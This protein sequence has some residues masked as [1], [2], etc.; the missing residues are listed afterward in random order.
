MICQKN[1]L[2]LS[3]WFKRESDAKRRKEERE[4]EEKKKILSL[5]WTMSRNPTYFA[6]YEYELK[7]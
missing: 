5:V 1:S 2:S 4:N 6:E 7:N 3:S